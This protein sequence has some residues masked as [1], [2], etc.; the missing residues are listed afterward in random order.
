MRFSW[1][2]LDARRTT[3]RRTGVG[4]SVPPRHR[5]QARAE[6]PPARAEHRTACTHAGVAM[7]QL[8]Q[9]IHGQGVP[10]NLF[11]NAPWR[12]SPVHQAPA[13]EGREHLKVRPSL[14]DSPED[15]VCVCAQSVAQH[16]ETPTSCIGRKV[17]AQHRHGGI[18]TGRKSF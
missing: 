18:S 8:Q 6:G 15:C 9:G 17:T 4:G 11:P 2:T 14:I 13:I 16:A 3:H 7:S 10:G 12:T 1:R 5:Q